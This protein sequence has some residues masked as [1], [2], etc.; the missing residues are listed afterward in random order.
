VATPSGGRSTRETAVA[1][2]R[3]LFLD[4]EHLHGCAETTFVV[5]K[6][7]FGLPDAEDSSAAMALNGGVAYSGGVCGAVTGS[8][9]AVGQLVASRVT[10]HA[11]AKRIARAITARLMDDFEAEFGAFDCRALLGR[12]IRTP[13]AHRAFIESGA[14]RTICMGQIEFAVRRVATLATE[15]QT[16]LGEQ[17]AGEEGPVPPP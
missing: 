9:M 12:D 5:L 11:E 2:A 8:A 6:E 16:G 10:E 4:D 3:A 7:A 17:L 15:S 14:W 1:R 13:E